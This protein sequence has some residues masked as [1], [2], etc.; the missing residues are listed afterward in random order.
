MQH[1]EL[2]IVIKGDLCTGGGKVS[3]F[4]NFSHNFR[5]I[6]GF[7]CGYACIKRDKTGSIAS[8]LIKL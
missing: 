1:I 2:I 8:I 7:W 6:I 3:I 4:S 5:K